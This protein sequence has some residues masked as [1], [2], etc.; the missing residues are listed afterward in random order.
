MERIPKKLKFYFRV[1]IPF[2]YDDDDRLDSR[3]FYSKLYFFSVARLGVRGE[4][5]G[6]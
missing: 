6:T 5:Y 4:T 2:P 1:A 3:L